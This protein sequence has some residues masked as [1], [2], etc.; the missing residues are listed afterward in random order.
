MLLRDAR[1]QEYARMDTRGGVPGGAV[2]QVGGAAT[3]LTQ[4]ETMPPTASP[5]PLIVGGP[6]PAGYLYVGRH[7]HGGAIWGSMDMVSLSKMDDA[8]PWFPAEDQ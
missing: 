1:D 3:S 5:S 6:Q 7:H 8:D 4:M 2:A